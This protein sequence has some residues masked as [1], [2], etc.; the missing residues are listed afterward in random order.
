VVECVGEDLRREV[1]SLERL[2]R[3]TDDNSQRQN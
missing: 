3:V 1:E 2:S